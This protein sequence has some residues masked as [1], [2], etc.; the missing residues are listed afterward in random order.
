M[1]EVLT[2]SDYPAI[3]GIGTSWCFKGENICKTDFAPPH[4]GKAQ[5][6]WL[7]DLDSICFD[8][9]LSNNSDIYIGV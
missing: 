7:N 2:S 6:F 5:L 3:E 4:G 8:V 9:S 1:L